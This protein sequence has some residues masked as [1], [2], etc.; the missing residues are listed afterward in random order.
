MKKF[1]FGAGD[2]G[3]AFLYLNGICGKGFHVDGVFDNNPNKWGKKLLGVDILNPAKLSNI[4]RPVNIYLTLK[5]NIEIAVEQLNKFELIEGIDFFKLDEF[6]LNEIE[7]FL[8]NHKFSYSSDKKEKL[9]EYHQ[10]KG[11]TSE[12]LL[13]KY[14]KNVFSQSGEDGILEYLLEKIGPGEKFCAEVGAV[15]GKY[16]SNVFNLV[17]N[18]AWT[19]LMIEADKEM[20]RYLQKTAEAVNGRIIPVYGRVDIGKYPLLDS[21]LNGYPQLDILSIKV[22]GIEYH[23]WESLKESSPRVVVVRFNPTIPSEIFFVQDY[24]K[25]VREGTSA[26]AFVELAME[27]S[28]E[29]VAVTVWNL[30]FARKDEY[31]KIWDNGQDNSLRALWSNPSMASGRIFQGFNGKIYTVGMNQLAWRSKTLRFDSVQYFEEFLPQGDNLFEDAPLRKLPPELYEAFTMN[32]KMGYME[33]YLDDRKSIPVHNTKECYEE[34]FSRLDNRTFQYYGDDVHSFYDALDDYSLND[35]TVLIFGLGGCNCDAIALW[36]GA[37]QVYIVDYNKPICEREN[38]M[39][40]TYDELDAMNIEI[41]FGFSFSSFEH[42]GLGRYGDHINPDGDL[43]AMLHA[44]KLIKKGGIMFLGVPLGCDCIVWNA[45]RIYGKARLPLLLNGW[46]CRD[47]YS[48]CDV[49]VFEK[50]LGTHI[51]PLLVIENIQA[52]DFKR[53]ALERLSY[54]KVLVSQGKTGTTKDG[55]ILKKILSWQLKLQTRYNFQGA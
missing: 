3:K 40:L 22:G 15:D 28:Y 26:S 33:C 11:K 48:Y 14:E 10:Q 20:F 39:V 54:A 36:N 13:N 5:K 42:D 18:H 41:D 50:P 44:K 21:F 27:K 1:I 4:T 30:I 29:L 9:L 32:R 34:V 45:H 35:K 37:K 12:H 23:I 43:S 25:E 55:E 49:G 6:I 16:M 53:A 47:A 38:V 31:L 46:L 52:K 2:I 17:K 7:L 24:D 8:L 51:Q 19:S